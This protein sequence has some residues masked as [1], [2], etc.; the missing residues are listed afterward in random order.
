[1]HHRPPSWLRT[2]DRVTF[3]YHRP[4]NLAESEQAAKQRPSRTPLPNP[5]LW[6]PRSEQGIADC[7]A[8]TSR[9]ERIK[10]FCAA[11]P[12]QKLG[13]PTRARRFVGGRTYM[14]I[15]GGRE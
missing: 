3:P 2:P 4:A 14:E 8:E 7:Q 9:M 13:W 1:M 5:V 15:S 10:S 12:A 11:K 6:S